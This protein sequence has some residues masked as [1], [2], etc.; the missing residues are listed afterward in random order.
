M[1]TI[2]SNNKKRAGRATLSDLR[3][4]ISLIISIS[5]FLLTSPT[6]I[7]SD[8]LDFL[9]GRGFFKKLW[10]SSPASTKASDG[11]G[12]LY[13]ARSCFMCHIN[14]GR[15]Q[16]PAKDEVAVSL[17]MRLS[18]P[19]P[20]HPKHKYKHTTI[21]EPR[22]GSQFQTAAVKGLPAEGRLQ[23]HYTDYPMR[24]ADGETIILKRPHYQLTDLK[25]GTLHADVQQS[26]RLAPPL[27]G[28]GLLDKL[29][30]D[31]ILQY[32]DPNDNNNDG[33][34]GKANLV[35]SEQ[36]QKIMLGRFGHKAGVATLD[37]QNQQALISDIG[38]STPL[39]PFAWG[40]CTVQQPDCRNAP[41]GNDAQY[42]SLEVPQKV[43]DSLF[44]YV[45]N[46]PAPA[47]RQST[48]P[49]VTLNVTLGENI[50]NQLGCPA[51][52]RKHYTLAQD[53]QRIA[54]YTDLLLHD[55]GA[56]L[57]DQRPEGD[58]TGTEWRT[59]PLWG[60]GLTEKLNGH[61]YYLHDGRAT[62]LAE[63]IL[64]H[65][66]EAKKQRDSY[67]RLTKKDRLALLTFLEYL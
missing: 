7:A 28:I 58:A 20:Q 44:F 53:Q 54:P 65:G 52:H 25:Y 12:P 45:S 34:S 43:I 40:D 37:E 13:N 50:F 23:I 21:A 9:V 1:K 24:F 30:A 32:S 51:C 57:A 18:I 64:W 3:V 66:G 35:W 55:M 31:T 2:L 26:P 10:V 62:T 15:G 39:F 38:L 36:K 42:Q 67:R 47:A 8:Q 61:H 17:L 56:D 63:A 22:Y 27:L 29:S 46:I 11:L 14:T 6:L 5:I 60:I 48:D 33:I 49:T 59:P 41:H 4:V 19:A 16:V